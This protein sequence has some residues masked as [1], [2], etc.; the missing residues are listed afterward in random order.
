MNNETPKLEHHSHPLRM[1]IR[2][3][4]GAE[5]DSIDLGPL[6][7]LQG[8]WEGVAFD[9]WNVIAV[10]GPRSNGGPGGFILEIIPYKEFLTYYTSKT[11]SKHRTRT[12]KPARY[13]SII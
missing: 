6:R 1:G 2:V 10:P 12:M 7:D 13:L 4:E 8:T 5:A 9:G 3:L 11:V